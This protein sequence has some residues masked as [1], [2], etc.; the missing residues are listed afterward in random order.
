MKKILFI[1]KHRVNYTN[2]NND[3]SKDDNM[4]LSSGLSNSV[5]FVVGMINRDIN[6]VDAKYVTVIDNNQIDKEVNKFRPDIVVIEAFWV[7]P[8]KFDILKKLHP[9][10]KWIVRNHSR[11][12]FL[13]SEGS[14]F[15]WICEY[16]KRGIIIGC[17]SKESYYDLKYISESL[18]I[19][20]NLILYL[21]NYY[22]ILPGQ[23]IHSLSRR[24]VVELGCFGAIRPLKNHMN[25]A[26]AAIAFSNEI[27]RRVNLHINC[28]RIEGKGDNILKN[29][30]N[31]FSNEINC[32][33][34][35]H[36]WVPHNEFLKIVSFMDIMLQVSLSESFNI[37]AADS[38]SEGVP[39]IISKEI[40]WLGNSSLISDID[41][42]SIKE[43]LMKIWKRGYVSN[44]FSVFRQQIAL[45]KF[46]KETIH[47]WKKLLVNRDEKRCFFGR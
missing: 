22:P 18:G 44:N 21:P 10:V 15:G 41:S 12:E 5:K 4:D 28:T 31:L 27:K 17:N 34:I 42:S 3:L 35:E 24:S 19:S 9:S 38:I 40:N 26:I 6:N 30:R 37:I 23:N 36:Q 29:L 2:W 39:V 16:L 45:D 1:L 43:T 20:K 47:Y 7:V 8:E 14:A 25:Q 33:L 13:S 11:S 32:K 46:N